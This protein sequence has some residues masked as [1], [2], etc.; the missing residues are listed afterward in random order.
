M[1]VCMCVCMNRRRPKPLP[2][3]SMQPI[4]SRPTPSH[5]H[6][7]SFSS[8]WWAW[9]LLLAAAPATLLWAGLS[10]TKRQ[11]EEDVARLQADVAAERQKRL[12]AGAGGQ[13][14]RQQPT[15]AAA[16]GGGGG[17]GALEKAVGVGA[18]GAVGAEDD[19]TMTTEGRLRR[20]EGQLARLEAALNLGSTSTT[21]SPSSSASPVHGE[22]PVPP[23]LPT[24]TPK[25]M[26]A[27]L[28][29]A[30][31]SGIRRRVLEA[32]DGRGEVLAA[33]GRWRK[34]GDGGGEGEEGAAD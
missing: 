11:M 19:A 5:P 7:N 13:A 29:A 32:Y 30:A 15:K 4:P 25:D 28:A 18:R 2:S 8:H 20:L 14:A 23:S 12:G 1:C 10:R 16:V 31:V 17:K 21:A 27:E 33:L 34:G 3:P 22:A 6:T 24:P 26:A 9:N